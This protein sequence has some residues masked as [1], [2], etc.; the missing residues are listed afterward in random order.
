MV[1]QIIIIFSY[2]GRPED[3]SLVYPTNNWVSGH[4][5]GNVFAVCEEENV[6]R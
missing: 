5:S 6:W 2:L 3:L 4:V 1:Y